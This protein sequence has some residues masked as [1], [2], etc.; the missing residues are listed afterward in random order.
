[1]HNA[2]FNQFFDL[3]KLYQIQSLKL[4]RY[5]PINLQ[6]G[7][8]SVICVIVYITIITRFSD[9]SIPKLKFKRFFLT[10]LYNY[11]HCFVFYVI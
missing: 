4:N 2:L 11:S 3:T 7:N 9:L 5:L 1:M 6:F 8:R 10:I